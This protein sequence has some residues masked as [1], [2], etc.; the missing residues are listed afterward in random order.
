MK[1]MHEAHGGMGHGK[2]CGRHHGKGM[3]TFEDIDTNGD[4]CIS[5]AEFD[6]HH[7]PKGGT[8]E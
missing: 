6:A 8:A 7:A 1:L 4:G 5:P 3:P 2:R